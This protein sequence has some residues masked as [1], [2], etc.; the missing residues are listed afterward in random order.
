MLPVFGGF[1]GAVRGILL[2][3]KVPKSINVRKRQF[4]ATRR[5]AKHQKPV[6]GF[7]A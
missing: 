6:N 5:E 1:K 4:A 7:R 2:K 3:E